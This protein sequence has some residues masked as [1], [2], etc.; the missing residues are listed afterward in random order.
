MILPV[1][2]AL[3]TYP[4][5]AF[6]PLFR[7]KFS[8]IL[9]AFEIAA[10]TA[11]SESASIITTPFN[12]FWMDVLKDGEEEDCVEVFVDFRI[13]VRSESNFY[14]EYSCIFIGKRNDF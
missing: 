11:S 1:F 8:L 5:R 13:F 12:F 2:E 4:P 3:T 10:E 9:T 6:S 7:E 14:P